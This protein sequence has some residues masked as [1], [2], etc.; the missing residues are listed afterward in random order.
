VIFKKGYQPR[1][2][3]G[4]DEKGD[5][6][7]GSHSILARWRNQ[8]SQLFVIHGISEVRQTE[9]HTAEPIAP[10]PCVF[11]FEMSIENIKG[12]KSTGVDQVP[13]ESI[14]E[15]VRKIRYEIY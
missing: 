10:E 3:I 11:E 13:T 15:G 5:L 9:I 4:Q 6:V 2:N 8:F 1:S 7:T 14:K 12:H